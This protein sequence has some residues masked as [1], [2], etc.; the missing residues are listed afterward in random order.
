M[1]NKA[2]FVVYMVVGGRRRCMGLGMSVSGASSI[3]GNMIV[4]VIVILIVGVVFSYFLG[5]HLVGRPDMAAYSVVA[6]NSSALKITCLAGTSVPLGSVSMLLNN[7]R[8]ASFT[9]ADTNGDGRWDPGETMSVTGLDLTTP[10]E[11]TI[12]SNSNVLYTTTVQYLGA[13]NSSA[14]PLS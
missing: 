6:V 10:K 1:A 14:A 12:A 13:N 5:F 2:V 3:I 9:L 7:S 8:I 4:I 11:L